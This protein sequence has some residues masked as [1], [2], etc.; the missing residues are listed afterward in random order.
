[1]NKIKISALSIFVLLGLFATPATSNVARAAYAVPECDTATLNG[2]IDTDDYTEVWFEWGEGSSLNNNTN[3]QPFSSNSNFSARINDLKED[4][5]Y[6]FR[7]MSTRSTGATLNFRTDDCGGG[8]GE[9]PV[10]IVNFEFTVKNSCDSRPIQGADVHIGQNF[11]NGQDRTTDGNGFSNFG[12]NS[13]TNI[14]WNVSTAGYSSK[15]GSSNSGNNGNMTNVSLT[16]TGGCNQPP[17]DVAAKGY[18]DEASCSVIKGWAFGKNYATVS[19]ELTD[20]TN[21]VTTRADQNRQDVGDAYPDAGDWHGFS[22]STPSIFKDSSSHSIRAYAIDTNG[23]RVHLGTSPKT[24]GPCQTQPPVPPTVNLTANPSSITRG[25][26]S[27]LSWTSERA[28]SCSASWTTSTGTSGSKVVSPTSTTTYSITCFGNGGQ[29]TDTA[30][31]TVVSQPPQTCQDPNATNYGGSL[32]CRYVQSPTVNLTANPTNIQQG[33]SSTLSWTSQNTTSCSASWTTSTGTSGSRSVS[34]GS[35]TTYSITCFGP[36]GQATDT[37]TVTVTQIGSPTVNLIANPTNIQQ[38]QSSTLSWTSQN[39]TSCSA[40]W[41]TS[42]GTSG[43]RIVAPGSTTTYSITCFGNGGQATDTAVVT[44]GT[45]GQAPTVDLRADDTSIDEGDETEL[46]WTSTNADS[47]SRTGGR[48]GWEDNSV[49][50]SGDFDTGDLSRDTTYTIRCV[51]NFGSDTD[52]VTVR[53]DDDDDNDRTCTDRNATNYGANGSCRYESVCQ[54]PTSLNYRGSLPCR[55][56]TTNAQ[57]PTV[58]LYADQTSLAYNGTTFVRWSTV[59][60]TSCEASGGSVGW[61]GTKSIGPGSFFTGSLS[62]SRTYNLTCYNASGSDSDS[63]TVSV[64]QP[65]TTGGP[66]PTPPPATSLVLVTSSIDR[67]QAILPTLDNT[68]PRPGDEITY[69]VNYQ[70]IGTGAIRNLVLRLD[71]PYEVVYLYSTPSNPIMSANTLIFNLGTLPANGSGTVTVRVRVR[72]DAPPGAL[73]NFPAMLSYIDPS[74]FPQTVTANV[75]AQVWNMQPITTVDDNANVLGAAAFLSG[76]FWP[77]SLFGWL[78]LII[79]ILLLVLLAKYLMDGSQ[80]FEKR[81]TTTTIQH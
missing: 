16:P 6:S 5:F 39:T 56:V 3:R 37:E 41:T 76:G 58:V 8:G 23:A 34:P 53:V 4:T 61:A 27:T 79:L 80:P 14:S 71:L 20:G 31:V 67:N 1:M 62:S 74:G 75:S 43:S 21:T 70:N 35:T 42:T 24:L 29:A 36:G 50:T 12:V 18:L 13:N 63:V 51:N 54:D 45:G 9:P 47:C 17:Q 25:D 15:S 72:E 38:G 60:A 28:N 46:T 19:V 48:N 65:P 57:R 2:Y 77:T 11:G 81:T 78:L 69:T 40:S 73:L 49:S 66:R 30:T 32:P 68:R 22:I 10:T 64:R 52:S 26:S 59:G 44:V 33:Q 55:Y 7:A